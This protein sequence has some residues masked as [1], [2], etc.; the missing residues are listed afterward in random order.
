MKIEL[1]YFAGCPSW[2][3]ALE[4]LRVALRE[5]GIAAT[6]ELVQVNSNAEAARL[7]FLG[8]PHFRVNGQDLWPEARDGYSMGCRLY[9]TPAGMS[10]EP[11]VEMLR[12]QLQQ[13]K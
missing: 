7:G 3:H 6:V 9:A 5:E 10:P 12:E 8:S 2:Q 4:S 13:F 11:S 1:L